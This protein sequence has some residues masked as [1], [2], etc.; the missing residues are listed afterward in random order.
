MAAGANIG[1]RPVADRRSERSTGPSC[2]RASTPGPSPNSNCSS[3]TTVATPSVAATTR[4]RPTALCRTMAA[5]VIG[6]STDAGGAQRRRQGNRHGRRLDDELR[7]DVVRALRR[8]HGSPSPG[9]SKTRPWADVTVRTRPS[10]TTRQYMLLTLR[11]RRGKGQ[12]PR[13]V[14]AQRQQTSAAARETTG[15]SAPEMGH[16]I[17]LFVTRR[18]EFRCPGPR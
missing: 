6:R 7:E 17:M 2:C 9:M 14:V 5:P 16:C 13:P 3:S 11:P 1:H 10:G 15:Q 18:R 8:R 4:S 12:L